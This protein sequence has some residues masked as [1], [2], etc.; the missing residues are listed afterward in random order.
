MPTTLHRVL[1]AYLTFIMTRHHIPDLSTWQDLL[2][3]TV[4]ALCLLADDPDGVR[5]IR[6]AAR[7]VRLVSARGR[8]QEPIVHNDFI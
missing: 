2:T 1:P 4:E 7:N 8:L 6:N 5:Q 3:Y